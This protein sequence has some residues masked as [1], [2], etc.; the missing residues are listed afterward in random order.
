[1]KA[2]KISKRIL[3][4]VLCVM[5]I[6]GCFVLPSTFVGAAGETVVNIHYLRD[7]GDYASWDVWAWADG[8][9][10]AG[11][12]FTDSGDPNGA[13]ATVTI[14]ESTPS[15]G[16]IVRKPD[17]SAKDPDGDRKVDLSSVVSG[18]VE[19]YC[20]AGSELND[21]TVDYSNAVQGLKL[22][23]A[24]A[25]SHTSI[26][27]EFTI[28]PP[29]EDNI[30]NEDFTITSAGGENVVI[31]SVLLN[32]KTGEIRLA[33]DQYIDYT[34]SYT[35][36]FR[37]S[38]MKLTLPDYFSTE[39]FES[40]Y[41]Y[42]G[43]DLGVTFAG[44]GTNFRVWAPTAQKVELNLYAAG[45]GGSAEQVVEM[46]KAEKGTWVAAADGNLSGMYYTYTA[47]FDGTTNKDIVDPYARSVGVNGKRGM[48]LDLDSTDPD[49]WSSDTYVTPASITDLE[50]YEVHVR[51]FSVDPDSGITN[52]GKYLAFTERGT[53]TSQGAK[54]GMD[55]LVDLGVNAV[56]ILPT[57]D[58]GSVDE[59]KLD[60][61]QF[62]WG[63]DPVNY[64]APEGSYSTDPY[65]GEVRVNE[66]KQMVKG[67][68]DAGMSVIMDVVYNHT[69]NTQYCFNQLVP[70][71]FYRPGQNTSGCGNDV[72]SERAMVRKFIVESVKYWASEYHMDGFRFDLMGILDVDTMNAVRAA[73]DEINPDIV[74]YGEGWNMGCQ[75]VKPG[76]KFANYLN[77]GA[78]PRI[79][80]FSDTLRDMIKGSVFDATEK[81][82]AN[83]ESKHYKAIVNTVQYTKKWCPSPSQI[84]NYT[85][86]HDNLTLW[87]KI[88]SSNGD[89]SE[90]DQIRQNNLAALIVHS[91]QGIPFMM[92]GEEFLR[93]KT[94]AD[95][96]FEH[97]SYASPDSVNQLDYNRTIQYANVYEYYKGLIEF[98]KS[99]P[100]FRLATAED[101]EAN[102]T[103]YL[104]NTEEGVAAFTLEGGVNG[105]PAERFLVIYNPLSEA[106]TVTLP[107]GDWDIYV[108]DEQAGDKVIATVSG[109]VSVPYLS[110]MILVQGYTPPAEYTTLTDAE[111]GV[112]VTVNKILPDDVKLVVEKNVDLGIDETK[113]DVMSTYKFSLVRNGEPY[114]IEDD[115]ATYMVQL[116]DP[117]GVDSKLVIV[118]PD[119]TIVE[120]IVG[121]AGDETISITLLTLDNGLAF[122]KEAGAEESSKP[123]ASEVSEV[124]EV[125][126]T[127]TTSEVSTVESSTQT[128][129]QTSTTTTTTTTT[130]TVD[131]V[132]TGDAAMPVIILTIAM[133]A[134]FLAFTFYKKRKSE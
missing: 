123:V 61:P 26:S 98:R 78:M 71:Y 32:G 39:E 114:V 83:G 35:I 113:W 8:L 75:S 116:K 101:V 28:T 129:T 10:S 100:A 106:T 95:G 3:A 131:T 73:V 31:S 63:Y 85:D 69:H 59:T 37:D 41:T 72:A 40:E 1:M 133:C 22:K 24:E 5:L 25:V 125:S 48:I 13:V 93:T 44:G 70:G 94:K 104:D 67:L 82:Y 21:F 19:V 112:S 122:V 119:G 9:D 56:Q 88:R 2:K 132:A 60:T 92:S 102:F 55:H 90:E 15:L 52:K 42:D 45:N 54:S 110:G 62:N 38:S 53:K 79:A 34:K 7:D 29:E 43:D 66:Y 80:F 120:T 47:Y 126:E 127:S 57:Y 118:Q 17:W 50:I 30:T 130:T 108:D 84:I 121:V 11:Y 124:S 99:H 81:G 36:S 46:D 111:T 134:A 6:I 128:S 14:T 65:H 23:T 86:C 58:Y 77:A 49:G 109:E 87:D 105:E 33:D 27:I 117:N 16:F 76:T 4:A 68:H 103:S 96:T 12:S 51:D 89:D 64:N 115:D 74:I 91:A 107:D 20:K 97:N 18:T